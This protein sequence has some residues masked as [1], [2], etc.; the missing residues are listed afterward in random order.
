VFTYIDRLRPVADIDIAQ[1]E[2][3]KLAY[4]LQLSDFL[5]KLGGGFNGLKACLHYHL[6]FHHHTKEVYQLELLLE[7][8][9]IPK[10]R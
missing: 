3:Q 6:L 4:M 10:S 5:S 2:T 7:F 9:R 1:D 8:L